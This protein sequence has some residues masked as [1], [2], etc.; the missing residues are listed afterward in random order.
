MLIL[1]YFCENTTLSISA[2]EDQSLWIKSFA[3]LGLRGVSTKLN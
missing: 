1:V 2:D 3:I